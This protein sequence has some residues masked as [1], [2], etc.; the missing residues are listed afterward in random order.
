MSI[1]RIT[2]IVLQLILKKYY[3]LLS[4]I[5]FCG[6][7]LLYIRPNL[8]VICIIPV[9][10]VVCCINLG[11]WHPGGPRHRI[12]PTVL[13]F[14]LKKYHHTVSWMY[15]CGYFAWPNGWNCEVI[16]II[17]IFWVIFVQNLDIW[18]PVVPIYRATPQC[19]PI[20]L[21]KWHHALFWM[22]FCGYFLL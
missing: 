12:T 19:F 16:C 22:Y 2:P 17:S 5:Y 7:F 15:F 21:K 11:I 9:F 8:G 20:I 6:Y 18:P 13:Q 10:G 14:I 4:W 3:H 1:Y